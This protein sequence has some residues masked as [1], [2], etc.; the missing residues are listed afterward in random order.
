[1]ATVHKG[2]VVGRRGQSPNGRLNALNCRVRQIKWLFRTA[3]SPPRPSIQR[4]WPWLGT[5]YSTF[6]WPINFLNNQLGKLCKHLSTIC[7]SEGGL[8][9]KSWPFAPLPNDD[10]FANSLEHWQAATTTAASLSL[11]SC[12]L[13]WAH[14]INSHGT[15]ISN[16][17]LYKLICQK[18]RESSTREVHSSSCK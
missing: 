10:S 6:Y 12:R 8:Y 16:W 1:M 11:L 2:T 4:I 3:K 14:L 17:Q 7:C 5:Q 15:L 9:W 13:M 18:L